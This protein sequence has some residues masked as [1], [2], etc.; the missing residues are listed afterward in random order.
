MIQL[1]LKQYSHIDGLQ[2]YAERTIHYE[3][4]KVKIH[5]HDFYELVIV[6]KGSGYHVIDDHQFAISDGDF[7]VILPGHNHNYENIDH[8]TLMNIL[9]DPMILDV[10]SNDMTNIPCFQ[11][12]F[13][14]H[15]EFSSSV[16]GCVKMNIN[17][18][19]LSEIMRLFNRIVEEQNNFQSGSTT[20]ILTS[21]IQMILILCRTSSP[22]DNRYYSHTYKISKAISYIKKNYPQKITLETLAE[23]SG[24][25]V[26]SFRRYFHGAVGTSPINYLLKLRLQKAA[27]LL[28]SNDQSIS[29]I[30]YKTGFSDSNYFIRQFK[31]FTGETPLKYRAGNHGS[32]YIPRH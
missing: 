7:F 2:L 17:E 29:E 18:E 13:N 20:F 10:F 11:I 31:K 3:S 12:M 5:D 27:E 1:S 24:L 6:Q 14:S 16:Q 8:L 28:D 9:F 19:N 30:A 23:I 32:F 15:S 25:S 4:E 21:F 26:S 22:V